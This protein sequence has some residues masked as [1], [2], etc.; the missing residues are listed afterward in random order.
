[1]RA[2]L[3]ALLLTATAAAAAD[4]ALVLQQLS[5]RGNEPFWAVEANRNTALASRLVAEPEEATYAGALTTLD[6]L[7]PPWAAF[8]GLAS[9][10][11]PLVLV[12]RA[13]AC[14][15]TMADLPPFDRRAVV[16]FAD[17][18]VATGCCR[19]TVAI[20]LAAAPDAPPEKPADDWSR[21]VADL[22]TSIR[23]CLIDGGIAAEAVTVAWPMNH[24]LAGV[25]LR[26]TAGARHDCIADLATGRI[27]RVDPVASAETAPLEGDPVFLPA[28]E[29]SPLLTCGHV[30]RV[31][32]P[33][34]GAL[35][36]WLHYGGPCS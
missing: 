9:D 20:D 29:A 36:G 12:A 8:H 17:G 31:V 23:A 26:D 2:S 1:M 10:G 30:E 34:T 15:D 4:D 27:D 16:V 3:A 33:G 6:F 14:L 32:D 24:G 35:L 13:E 18:V 19:G 28:R 21:Y 11:T 7:D 22:A 25:R 5:C